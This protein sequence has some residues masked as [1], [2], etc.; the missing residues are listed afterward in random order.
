MA[1]VRFPVWERQSFIFSSFNLSLLLLLFLLLF[2]SFIKY[3]YNIF[4]KNCLI[5]K[6]YSG[7]AQLLCCFSYLIR[8]TRLS[9]TLW[10][11][12]C[13][14]EFPLEVEQKNCYVIW[15]EEEKTKRIQWTR[16]KTYCFVVVLFCFVFSCLHP[17]PYPGKPSLLL[18]PQVPSIS[19]PKIRQ[20]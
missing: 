19:T 15:I 13:L 17:N 20:I 1:R 9:F 2:N 10:K 5:S 6:L 14:T 16:K 11:S 7:L 4:K 3:S 18:L 8:L 12:G